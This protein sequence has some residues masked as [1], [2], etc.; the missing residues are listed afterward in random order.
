MAAI[1]PVRHAGEA[2][3][4]LTGV[5]VDCFVLRRVRRT[6]SQVGLSPD[7]RKRNVAGAFKVDRARSGRL[8]GK[9]VVVVDDVITTGATAAS[10]ARALKRAKA[11]RVDVLALARVIEPTAF[12]L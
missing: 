8:T 1:Q 9:K 12:V 6:V 2:L 10:C 5:P 4:R 11:A 3:G 7:Q